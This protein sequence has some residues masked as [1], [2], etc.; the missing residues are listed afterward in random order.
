MVE[1]AQPRRV[2]FWDQLEHLLGEDDVSV[3]EFVV[4]VYEWCDVVSAR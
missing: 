2:R 1:V 3:F 4:G